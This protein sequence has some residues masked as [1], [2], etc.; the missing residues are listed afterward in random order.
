MFWGVLGDVDAPSRFQD[1]PP[2]NHSRFK[3]DFL[4]ENVAPRAESGPS[5]VPKWVQKCTFSV[6]INIKSRKIDQ[7]GVPEKTLKKSK[8]LRKINDF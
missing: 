8:H 3:V 5:L 4:V 7:G 2:G 6:K 1:A